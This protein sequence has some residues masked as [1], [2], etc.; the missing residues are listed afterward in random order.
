MGK[1]KKV[2]DRFKRF[3]T[4][5]FTSMTKVNDFVDYLEQGKVMGT[6]CKECGLVFFPPRGDCHQCLSAHM[7]WFEDSGNVL[8]RNRG[9]DPER[10]DGRDP[11]L[12]PS[13]RL[14]GH[15]R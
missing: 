4:V 8:P 5:S 13:P 15:A 3:G 9:N 11:C 7:K 6:R 1:R 2:D 12:V 14:A 10:R